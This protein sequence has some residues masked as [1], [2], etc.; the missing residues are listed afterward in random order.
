MR[1]LHYYGLWVLVGILLFY[2]CKQD[3]TAWSDLIKD[4]AHTAELKAPLQ[5]AFSLRYQRNYPAAARAFESVLKDKTIGRSTQID[6]LNQLGFIYLEMGDTT[7]AI[8]LLDKLA[9]QESDFNAFQRADYWYNLGV[10]NL[11]RI[12]PDEA[13]KT[14]RMPCVFI[15]PNILGGTCAL[16]WR[17]HKWPSIS[18]ILG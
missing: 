15:S 1:R 7:A 8:P 9:K 2:G 12:N 16:L 3:T 5:D 11:Q 10:L 17:I 14:W 18:L 6:V 4:H 13:K